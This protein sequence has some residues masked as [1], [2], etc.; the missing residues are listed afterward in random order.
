MNVQ[1]L[2]ESAN[3]YQKRMDDAQRLV[4]KWAKSG[5]LENLKNDIEK[6]NVAM[7]LENQAKQLVLEGN[8]TGGTNSMSGG[9]YHSENWAGV[10]L[11]LVS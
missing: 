11:P 1:Q 10:A 3:P 6:S 2:L 5:L 9:G 7:L 4:S 8:T